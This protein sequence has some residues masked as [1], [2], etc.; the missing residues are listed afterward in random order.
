MT[1]EDQATQVAEMIRAATNECR[2]ADTVTMAALSAVIAATYQDTTDRNHRD[3]IAILIRA[4][5]NAVYDGN[6]S[7]VALVNE[8]Y[9]DLIADGV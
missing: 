2:P 3:G 5:D 4:I 7:F 1:S 9:A 8:T 6:D